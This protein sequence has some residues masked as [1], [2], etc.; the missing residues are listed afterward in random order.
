MIYR[1]IALALITVLTAT[2]AFGAS[3]S[4]RTSGTGTLTSGNGTDAVLSKPSG[5]TDGD[6]MI[7]FGYYEFT[8]TINSPSGWTEMTNSPL[9]QNGSDPDYRHRVW[10]KRASSEPASWTWTW[11]SSSIWRGMCISTY[12]GVVGTGD[13]TDPS[14][15]MSTDIPGSTTDSANAP[16]ITT[17]FADTMLVA[18]YSS[19][20]GATLSSLTAGMSEA[21]S[22]GGIYLVDGT[23][24]SAGASGDKTGTWSSSSWIAGALI[25]L[26]STQSAAFPAATINNPLQY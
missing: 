14:S 15:G 23:Q 19:F 9:A 3:P 22:Q 18:T 21:V 8:G 11:D 1:T 10:W 24:A 20:A 5:V 13:P 12:Q 2:L 7:A 26:D 25:A 4:R 6:I 17:D 16:S